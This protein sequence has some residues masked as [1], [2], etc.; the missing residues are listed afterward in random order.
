MLHSA[1]PTTASHGDF[2]LHG[3]SPLFVCGVC[4]SLCSTTADPHLCSSI[5]KGFSCHHR[6]TQC[7]HMAAVCQR[8]SHHYSW[9]AGCLSCF[10]HR[11]GGAA[12]RSLPLRLALPPFPTRLSA[13]ML[14]S[15]EK[16]FP[17]VPA[18]LPFTVYGLHILLILLLNTSGYMKLHKPSVFLTKIQILS[19]LRL[20]SFLLCPQEQKS[21]SRNAWLKQAYANGLLQ[22][23][24]FQASWVVKGKW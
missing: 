2:C 9:N 16:P 18:G 17:A 21:T 5:S 22:I 6:G 24:S 15:S 10:S 1:I 11:P 23:R 4:G 14:I 12:T 20:F 7:A 19:G 13:Q 3:L 8:L